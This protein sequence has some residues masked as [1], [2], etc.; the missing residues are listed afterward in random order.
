MPQ[1]L[2]ISINGSET[3]SNPPKIVTINV[4]QTK[5]KPPPQAATKAKPPPAEPPTASWSVN[6]AATAAS[7]NNGNSV[8]GANASPNGGIF[9][10]HQTFKNA[11]ECPLT[12]SQTQLSSQD[13]GALGN[14]Y[15]KHFYVE[16]TCSSTSPSGP[17]KVGQRSK[18][19]ASIGGPTAPTKNWKIQLGGGVGQT[20][21]SIGCQIV[22]IAIIWCR[23]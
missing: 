7:V 14:C 22:V 20:V 19:P 13:L 12:V 23:R 9:T 6:T 21:N 17:L 11:S 16:P 1:A 3:H 5:A 15:W 18:V 2:A 4:A 8:G 10:V